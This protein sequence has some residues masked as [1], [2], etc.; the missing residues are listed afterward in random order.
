MHDVLS[1]ISWILVIP[2][3]IALSVFT[4]E[5]ILGILP[6]KQLT[7]GNQRPKTTILM[8]AHNEALNI[9][10]TLKNLLPIL[11]DKIQIL[12][13]ADNCNDNT[14]ALVKDMGI[15]V[16]ERQAPLHRGKGYALA[17]GQDHLRSNPPECV[18]ILDADCE[19]DPQSVSDLAALAIRSGSPVQAQNLIYSE[20]MEGPMV[21]ISNFAF[22][23]KNAVRQRGVNRLGGAALL[24]GTGMAFPWPL[25]EKLPLATSSIVEDLG[26][27][28][29]LTKEG[30]PPVYLDQALVLSKAADESETINQRSRWEIGFLSMAR[31]FGLKSL[32]QGLLRTDRKLF[33]LG[34]HLLV[35]PIALLFSTTL[36]T[37]AFI[38][39][40]SI[41][42]N[43]MAPLILLSASLTIAVICILIAWAVG[44]RSVLSGRTIFKLPFYVM[45]KIPIYLKVLRKEIPEWKRTE[46]KNDTDL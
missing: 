13:V 8:P 39:L 4:I 43:N 9:S 18:I 12:V 30:H 6:S 36:M 24:G 7:L 38:T 21:Q 37:L 5:I 46:R 40:I 2:F 1:A 15:D 35:P 19:T 32:W 25:F 44:G 17:F 34:L 14:A 11:T 16:I 23:I 41:V 42:A 33:Q 26:L 27:G 31:E 10:T 3:S 45:W 22:W 20:V 29:Y 28:I